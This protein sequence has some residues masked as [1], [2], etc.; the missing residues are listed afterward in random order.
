MPLKSRS[1]IP[2]MTLFKLAILVLVIAFVGK[3][4]QSGWAKIVVSEFSVRNLDFRWLFVAG[5][6][7]LL[8]MLPMALNWHR[9]LKAMGAPTPIVHAIRT[10][11][12]SQ[13]GK[14]VPGK[15]VVVAIRLAMVKR[16]DVNPLTL[17][18]SIVA[19]TLGMLSVG[20]VLAAIIVVVLYRNHVEIAL[21]AGLVAVIATIPLLPPVLRFGLDLIQERKAR[22]FRSELNATPAPDLTKTLT[23]KAVVP[24]WL[25]LFPGFALFG[26]SLWAT[27]KA[28]NVAESAELGLVDLPYVT[29]AYAV[30]IVAGF[31]S[32]LPGG[33]GAREIVLKEMLEPQHGEVLATV[34]PIFHRMA[35][36]V[37]ELIVAP[38][39]YLMSREA[40]PEKTKRGERKA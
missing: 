38:I 31:A 9:L 3:T 13:L 12:V 23:W 33:L 25:G 29:A 1:G 8:G 26:V 15:A 21:S 35:I 2:W 20:S 14:Y 34:A 19:D 17:F 28:M 16:F 27:M 32:M 36:I 24:G 39:F 22:Y 7:Y 5:V 37:S 18:I 4:V 11:Y 10:H 6:C 30:S 40:L